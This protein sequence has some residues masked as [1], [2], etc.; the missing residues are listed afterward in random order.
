MSR[1]L[2]LVDLDP[3]VYQKRGILSFYPFVEITFEVKEPG[4]HYHVPLLLS[5]YAFSTYRGS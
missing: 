4:E 2:T 5:P 1:A 3:T